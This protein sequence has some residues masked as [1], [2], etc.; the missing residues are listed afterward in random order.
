[1]PE[2]F[3]EMSVVPTLNEILSEQAAYLRQ[4]LVDGPYRGVNHYLDVHFRLLR[5]DFI[6]PLREAIFNF[7]Q[8][9]AEATESNYNRKN[10][11]D[12]VK[13]TKNIESLNVYTNVTIE[14][15][16]LSDNGILKSHIFPFLKLTF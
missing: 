5:E 4:N 16:L 9:V 2:S 10:A 11:I 13:N 6:Q 7:R 15:S 1:M 3:L 12:M 8:I 14:S